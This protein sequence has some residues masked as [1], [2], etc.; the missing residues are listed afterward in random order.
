MA[1]TPTRRPL[2]ALLVDALSREPQRAVLTTPDRQG[3]ADRVLTAGEVVAEA[4]R[5]ADALDVL[6]VARGEAVLLLSENR[7]R[8]FLCD[9]ALLGLGCPDVPRGADAPADEIGYI[10]EKVAARVA[11]VE[12]PELLARIAGHPALELVVLLS[13]KAVGASS[14]DTPRI[15]TYEELLQRR[16]AGR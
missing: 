5:V 8:W 3:G 11:I 13:G 14:S 1:S 4:A 12:K 10:V 6:G 2:A 15:F 9:L 16:A 7:E